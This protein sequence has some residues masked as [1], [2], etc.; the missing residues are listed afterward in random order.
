MSFDHALARRK[1]ANAPIGEAEWQARVD[2]AACYR[3]AARHGWDD[4]IY[5][6]ISARVPGAEHH[7]LINPF[8]MSFDEITA[9][10]L[11]KIDLGGAIV[12]DSAY[13]VNKAGFVI[14][15]AVH[16]ARPQVGCVMHTHTENGMAISMLKCG[17]LPVSQHAMMFHD[18]LGYH[19]YEGIALDAGEKVR[20]VRDLGNHGS[21]ILRNHGF[22]TTG[23]T[24]A[25]AFVRMFNLEKAAAAQLK[26]MTSGDAMVVPPPEVCE[27]TARQFESDVAPCGTREWPAMLRRLDREDPSYRN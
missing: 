17:L 22:L 26:A 21:M 13:G 1:A 24:V 15:S 4:L 2:L 27:K 16:E 8:G 20:L 23:G 12:G 25:E 19:D 11:V 9:S 18:R 10:S 7:F 3:L 14:H 5:T 6:H